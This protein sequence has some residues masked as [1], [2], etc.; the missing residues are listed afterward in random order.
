MFGPE[1]VP[2]DRRMAFL[3][4]LSALGILA[5]AGAVT[6]VKTA[7]LP[8]LDTGR[9]VVLWILAGLLAVVTLLLALSGYWIWSF[10]HNFS[11]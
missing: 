9:R 10:M 1:P 4:M 5:V 3:F 2:D 8:E 11:F 7:T 6:A